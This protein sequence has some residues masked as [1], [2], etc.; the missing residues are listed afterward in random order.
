MKIESVDSF[1]AFLGRVCSSI[2][3]GMALLVGRAANFLRG[4]DK[5]AIVLTHLVVSIL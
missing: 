3:I 1:H 4:S 2:L 5:Q